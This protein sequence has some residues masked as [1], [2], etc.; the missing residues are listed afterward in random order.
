MTAKGQLRRY[1]PGPVVAVGL[2][3]IADSSFREALAHFLTQLDTN[4]PNESWPVVVK[5]K[6]QTIEVQDTNHPKFVTEMLTGILRGMGQPLDV[7]CIFKSTRDDV[8]WNNA[9]KP[10]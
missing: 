4:T 8:L 1:F 2:N 10:W 5:A 9:F 6:F 3:K 7:V